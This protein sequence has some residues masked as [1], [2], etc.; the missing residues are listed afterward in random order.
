M[1][2]VKIANGQGFWGDSIDA[3]R[4]LIKYGDIDYLTLDYLAEVTISIMQ[5]QKKKNPNLGYA[6][7]FVNLIDE[8]LIDIKE[9][10]IRVIA[11][12]GG[13]NPEACRKAILEISRKKNL[14]IKV[15][16]I[17]GDDI[18]ES[19]DGLV[20]QGENFNNFYD[21]RSFDLIKDKIYSANVYI[22]SFSVAEALSL[23]AD[24]VL[25]GRVSDPGLVVGPC[26]YEFGWN[27]EQY[28]LL[29][30][31][32]VAGHILECGAQCTGGN[33]SNW[34]DVKDFENIGYPVVSFYE[35]GNFDVSKPLN[36]GGCINKFTVSEQLLYELGNP[37]EYISPDVCVDFTSFT[38]KEIK[39]NVVRI[40][41]V[42]GFSPTDTFKVSMSYFDGY[43]ASGILTISGPD[44][45]DKS[46]KA[47]EIVWNKLNNLGLSYDKT[48]T[49]YLG[50]SSC[51][52]T[53]YRMPNVINEIVL[54]LGVKSDCKDSVVRFTKE[55]SPL[56]TSGPPGITG[57]SEGRP[58]VRDIVAYWPTLI[59]KRS[60]KTTVTIE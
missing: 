41:G 27:K 57:F 8:S 21:G 42:K 51:F 5:R 59:D 24:I 48:S 25:C 53:T 2:V 12:A 13:V 56:I 60:I 39:E 15:A 31:A 6:T 36:T 58:R 26:I 34:K 44:A 3:P 47:S 45:L 43:K 16:V 1:K 35:S 10:N 54:R 14:K 23:G 33:Y 18:Y 46:K 4:N 37:M 22:D 7:D 11:N 40:E 38:L 30:S 20:N 49:E 19:L 28:D 9:N 29:A 50:L 17:K 32:T 55:L 52:K